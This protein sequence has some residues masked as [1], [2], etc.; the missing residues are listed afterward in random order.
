MPT[1]GFENYWFLLS[2]LP[3]AGVCAW[4]WL[5]TGTPLSRPRKVVGAIGLTLALL[6]LVMG[7]AGLFW[8]VG[9]QRQTVWVLVDRSLSA[10]TRGEARLAAVLRE[11]SQSLH[12]DDLIGV[13]SF[14]DTPQLEAE[15][16]SARRF[17]PDFALS[18]MKPSEETYLAPALAFARQRTPLGTSPVAFVISD[19][20]D[21]SLSYGG[22]LQKEARAVGVKVFTLA[23]DSDPLP[24]VALADFAAR[25][26]G[27]ERTRLVADLV[28][29]STVRQNIKLTLTVDR[30]QVAVKELSVDEGRTPVRLLYEPPVI[31]AVYVVEAS[32][33]SSRDT[34]TSNNALKLAVRGPGEANILLV[35]GAD[36][37]DEALVRALKAASLKVTTG[38]AATLPSDPVELARYQVIV[39]SD[40]PATAF[41]SSTLSMLEMFTRQGGG[42]AMIGGPR[43]FAPGGY[44]ETAV[45][46]AL[47]VTCNVTE[48]GRKQSPAMVIALDI[49]GSM[50][51][52]AGRGRE[53]KID[54]ANTGCVLTIQLLGPGTHF[55]M[56]ATSTENNWVVPLGPVTAS[57]KNAAIQAAKGN[58]A[59]GGGINM[60]T[61]VTE[62]FTKLRGANTSTKHLVLFVDGDDADEQEGVVEMIRRA[63]DRDKITVSVICLGKGKD[64]PFLQACAQAGQGRF[65]LVIDANNLP[66]VFSREAAQVGGNFIREDEFRPKAGVPGFFTEGFDFQSKE[67]PPLLGY[68]ATSARENADTWLW[69]D[70]EEEKPERPLL[71]TWHYGL[72]KSLA[73]T[74]D[75]RDRWADKWLPWGGYSA[76]WQRWIR[77]L[78]PRPEQLSGVETEWSMS[79]DG[80]EVT[81]TFF[82]QEGAPRQLAD[83]VAE[84]SL[85]D[86]VQV[87]T[88]VVAVGSGAYRVRFPKTGSGVYAT[89][90]RERP[91]NV[92]QRLVAREHQVFVPLDELRRRSANIAALSAVARI[93]GGKLVDEAAYL[94]SVEPETTYDQVKPSTAFFW[95]GLLGMF[96]ALGARRFPTVWLPREATS[97]A[98]REQA[99]QR[100][101][102]S[103]AAF[104]RVRERLDT[105][106]RAAKPQFVASVLPPTLPPIPP[107]VAPL[108]PV[109]P[110]A[111]APL[112]APRDAQAKPAPVQDGGE[113]L[114]GAMRRVKKE[115]DARK[116]PG[117]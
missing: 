8:N 37:P 35:H 16:Q 105:R 96:L 53:T 2:A 102:A 117:P 12:E 65:E 44:F 111:A 91:P 23:V 59:G 79:R 21:T 45:E 77:W 84:I 28:V 48:R 40:V 18:P 112:P 94:G 29:Y 78:L 31:Q 61:S 43:S 50:G 106:V 62:A 52:M 5:R 20:H 60:L 9:S 90:V 85:P 93:T 75:A 49:S 47:P 72:G 103:R 95:L 25:V 101:L 116:G 107:P 67:T 71:A 63:N 69:A 89:T 108:A 7:S 11:L 15:P 73:F 99:H 1:I 46:K 114:L 76:L 13:I 82:D 39:L 81:L 4:L 54:L 87:D 110:V 97:A 33:A 88:P 98:A 36:G 6:G 51:A 26:A 113:G 66:V 57:N 70:S 100:E 17:N 68:V 10:G 38:P 41:S 22:D 34:S 115:L 86:G 74:S 92:E 55:G 27:S 24:E 42:L 30:K 64:V 109:T 80:P 58:R 56:L 83:P 19:G 3:V 32:V 14:S 104:E